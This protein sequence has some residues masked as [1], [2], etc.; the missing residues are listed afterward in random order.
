MLTLTSISLAR[1]K[2]NAH[3]KTLEAPDDT[4]MNAKREKEHYKARET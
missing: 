1:K 2:K 4:F 3:L